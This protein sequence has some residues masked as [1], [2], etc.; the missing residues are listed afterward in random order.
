MLVRAIALSLAILVGIGVIVPLATDTTEAGPRKAK[1]KKDRNWRG[2][3]KYSKR[4]WQL[5]RA[6]ERR[7]RSLSAR[8]RALRLKQIRMESA[9]ATETVSAPVA[10]AQPSVKVAKSSAPSVLPTGDEAPAGWK[11][12]QSTPA[13][14]QFR[15]DNSA[16][17]QVGSA[18]ISVVGPA[19]SAASG[20]KSVGGVSTSTLRREVIDR[21]IRENG[22]VVND[23]QKDIAGQPVYV[24]VA[25]SQAKSGSVQSRMFYFTEVDGRIYSVATNSPVQESERLAEESEKVINS[26]KTRVRPA[27]RASTKD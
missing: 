23:Y 21:M 17:D 18:S 22:W 27:L 19:V 11:S 1:K 14:L 15:V 7:K 12:A 6:Q 26:L 16:G 4:W 24:V 2:V 25:Q 5:Y 3:R 9:R 8:K 13:E 20:P 10:K